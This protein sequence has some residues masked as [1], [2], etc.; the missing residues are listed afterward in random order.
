VTIIL[1]PDQ[2]TTIHEAMKA[3][4]IRSVEEFV[5]IAIGALPPSR[6]LQSSRTGAVAR[7]KEFGEMHELSLGERISRKLLHEGHRF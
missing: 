1:K 7:M 5:D 2:E 3:G 4:L 6:E